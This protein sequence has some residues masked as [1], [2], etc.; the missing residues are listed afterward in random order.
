[1]LSKKALAAER[2]SP[3][4]RSSTDPCDHRQTSGMGA[5]DMALTPRLPPLSRRCLASEGAADIR[6]SSTA[7]SL[8]SSSREIS[9]P[10]TKLMLLEIQCG[11][12]RHPACWIGIEAEIVLHIWRRP[13]AVKVRE[14]DTTA[15]C[16]GRRRGA[17]VKGAWR[18]GGGS[19]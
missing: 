5:R 17:P 7:D 10:S 12:R 11:H 2:E 16:T 3:F 19:R 15:G 14:A 8:P 9:F 13:A 4:L 6:S 1:M 18:L